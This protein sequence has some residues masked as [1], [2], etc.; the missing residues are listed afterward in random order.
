MTEYINMINCPPHHF[1][2]DKIDAGKCLKCGLVVNFRMKSA[3]YIKSLG[4]AHVDTADMPEQLQGK[5]NRVIL[6]HR[7]DCPAYRQG[8]N[9]NKVVDK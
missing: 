1:E 7:Q 3:D 6:P 2:V 5:I 4:G 9:K 8:L